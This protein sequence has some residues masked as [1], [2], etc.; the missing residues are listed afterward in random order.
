MKGVLRAY[1]KYLYEKLRFEK[2]GYE[3]PVSFKEWWELQKE[4]KR[5]RNNR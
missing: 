5:I 3:Y 2:D 4:V 1:R